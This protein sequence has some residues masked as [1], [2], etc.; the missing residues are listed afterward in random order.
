M[1]PCSSLERRHP[2]SALVTDD[3]PRRGQA[4]LLASVEPH[5]DRQLWTEVDRYLVDRLVPPD[6]G[7]RRLCGRASEAGLPSINV[8]PNQGKLLYLLALA[9]RARTVLEIGTLGGYSTIWLA[10]ALPPGGSLVT[11]ELDPATPQVA[12]GEYRRSRPLRGGGDHR[13][14]GR[15]ES[16]R[17]LSRGTGPVSTSSSSTPT[18]RAPPSTSTWSLQLSHVGSLIVVDNVVRGGQDRSTETN[19]DPSVH[20]MQRFFDGLA[21]EPTCA[22]RRRSRPSAPRATTAS[23]LALVTSESRLES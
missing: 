8:A 6:P 17:D 14:P 21:S 13:R 11:L 5:D 20:G 3:L 12:A 4:E 1:L 19:D 7:S 2:A 15:I 22:A 18:R 23:S 9:T 16:S 10:R